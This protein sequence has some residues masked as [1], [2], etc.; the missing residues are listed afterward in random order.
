MLRWEF[1][2]GMGLGMLVGPSEGWV[3]GIP[4]IEPQNP[5]C[6]LHV[7]WTV[8]IPYSRVSTIDKT[9]LKDFLARVFSPKAD[10]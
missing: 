3:G 2:Y 4:S 8:L 6:P 1:V 7:L 9:E 10:L 5:R